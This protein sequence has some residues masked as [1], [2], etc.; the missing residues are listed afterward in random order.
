MLFAIFNAIGTP[1][2]ARGAK[3]E[4]GLFHESG[5]IRSRTAMRDPKAPHPFF[6]DDERA[7]RLSTEQ[8]VAAL[9]ENATNGGLKT[10]LP[11]HLPPPQPIPGFP[12]FPRKLFS[13]H[14]K[15]ADPTYARV[16]TEIQDIL[17]GLI[18]ADRDRRENLERAYAYFSGDQTAPL[19][20]GPDSS[21]RHVYLGGF[22]ADV[23]K[24]LDEGVL[25]T[26]M[27]ADA[28]PPLPRHV[29]PRLELTRKRRRGG[30]A[31]RKAT[32]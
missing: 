30:E 8:H 4:P 26:S 29:S 17:D 2:E 6:V 19:P 22:E 23:Q 14:M 10:P 28:P 20:A 25:S 15:G 11:P 21:P 13:E 31:A 16:P 32:K 18:V 27:I 7:K 3:N 24:L 9:R 5:F 1:E 12:A